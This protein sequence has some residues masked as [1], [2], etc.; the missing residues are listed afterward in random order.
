MLRRFSGRTPF[1][2][3]TAWASHVLHPLRL[4]KGKGSHTL[5]HRPSNASFPF[6]LHIASFTGSLFHIM[7]SF[8]YPELTGLIE[9]IVLTCNKPNCNNTMVYFYCPNSHLSYLTFSRRMCVITLRANHSGAVYCYR[10]CLWRAGERRAVSVTTITRNCVH[11]F[12]PNWV[13]R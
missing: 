4:L 1:L 5:L 7:F 12:S 8:F 11:R 9:F 10:S 3:P 13:C 6:A 2:L